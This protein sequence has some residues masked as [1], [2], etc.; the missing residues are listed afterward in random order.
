MAGKV[1]SLF[2]ALIRVRTLPTFVAV[3]NQGTPK[4]FENVNMGCFL[5]EISINCAGVLKWV[6]ENIRKRSKIFENVQILG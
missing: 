6:F 1:I 2:F 3:R 4:A 5:G